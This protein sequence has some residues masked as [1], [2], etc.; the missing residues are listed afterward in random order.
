MA[1]RKMT[2]DP[3]A[4]R[5][6]KKYENPIPSREFILELLKSEGAPSALED[7]AQWLNLGDDEEK[8]EAL[9]RRLQAMCRDGQLLRSRRNRY[10][11][12]SDLHL[13]AGTVIGH[14]DGYG[15]IAPDDGSERLFLA[16]HDMR[17]V[18]DGDRVLVREEKRRNKRIAKLVEITERKHQQIVGRYIEHGSVGVVEPDNQRIN[19]QIII[20]VDKRSIAQNGQVVMVDILTP[21]SKH[22]P[23][24]GEVIE[25]LGDDMAPGMETELAIRTHELPFEWSK[26]C[27]KE[28]KKLPEKVTQADLKDRKDLRDLPFVTIDGEDAK[29]FDDALYC[30]RGKHDDWHLYVA[31]ADVSHYVK[32]RTMLDEEALNRGNSVYFPNRVIP[33]LPEKLSNGL[34]SLLP[35]ADRLAMVCEMKISAKG[36]V[37]E[38]EFYTA[39]IHSHARLTYTKVADMVQFQKEDVRKKYGEVV[40]HVDDLY[41]LYNLLH[42]YRMQQGSLYFEIPE[43]RFVF[44]KQLK[45]SALLESEKNHAHGMVEEC[46]LRANVETAKFILASKKT[47]IYRVHIGPKS[48]K[49][50]DLHAFL[51]SLG[52]N[53]GGGLTPSPKD[54]AKLVADTEGRGDSAIV[55]MQLLRSMMQAYYSTDCD[56]HFGLAFKAYSHFTSPIRRYPDLLAHRIIKTI[57]N[58]NKREAYTEETMEEM[59]Q[60]CSKTERRAEEATRDVVAWLKCEYMHEKVGEEFDAIITSVCSFGFFVEIK[61]IFVEGLV[62]VTSLANDYYTFDEKRLCLTGQRAQKTYN[63]G[64]RIKV[65]LIRVSLPDKRIDFELVNMPKVKTPTKPKKNR[66]RKK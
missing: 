5:E 23:A 17:R 28:T 3:F 33:M 61:G 58:K 40:S 10:G 39:V 2:K 62:H 51:K 8:L 27:E 22:S 55:Q 31:I 13:I 47:G 46:M 57:I 52:L 11:L 49:I 44:D 36:K 45:I 24:V 43:P 7:I 20:P 66:R 14:R 38:S 16:G 63:L 50:M 32:A 42:P 29:D 35:N 6:A 18:F 19:Q 4:K 65:R 60:R 34:C 41:A 25:V 30:V 64:D 12:I 1:K 48:E 59:A 56:I 9:R 15:M 21:P 26:A 53:L 54:Y 37:V